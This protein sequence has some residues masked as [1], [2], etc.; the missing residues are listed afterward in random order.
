[1]SKMVHISLTEHIFSHH[2]FTPSRFRYRNGHSP[3]GG[4]FGHLPI[5][6]PSNAHTNS[7]SDFIFFIV[8]CSFI[9]LHHYQNNTAQALYR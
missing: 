4:D 1:M 9:R 2:F 3:D 8:V 6:N 5:N 7:I